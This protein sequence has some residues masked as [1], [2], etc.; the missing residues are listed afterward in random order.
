MTPL[1]VCHC[2]CQVAH[3]S[4]VG[5]CDAWAATETVQVQTRSLG[6]VTVQVCRPCAAATLAG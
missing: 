1:R 4:V 3:P 5:V 6:A 2:L